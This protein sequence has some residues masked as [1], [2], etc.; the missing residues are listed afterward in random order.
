MRSFIRGASLLLA[1]LAV[2]TATPARA[3]T[4][5]VKVPFAFVVHG[6]TLP[7]GQYLVTDDAGVVQFE[8]EH[9]TRAHAF[10]LTVPASGRD[11]Q[12]NKPALV[13]AKRE[14]QYRLQDIW[15]SRDIGL[16]PV[17]Q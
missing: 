16:A 3:A 12:G 5:E 11:P 10:L 4:I 13:F 2:S 6:E 15:E 1:G 9:G 7:A 14:N 17:K 8:G